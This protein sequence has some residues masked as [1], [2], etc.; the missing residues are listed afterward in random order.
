MSGHS[1][2]N[3][4]KKLRMGRRGYVK[5]NVVLVERDIIYNEN[6]EKK[7]SAYRGRWLNDAF[8]MPYALFSQRSVKEIPISFNLFHFF[9]LLFLNRN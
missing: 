5:R 2:G 6:V 7:S 9:F 4:D 1:Q 3:G 8:H